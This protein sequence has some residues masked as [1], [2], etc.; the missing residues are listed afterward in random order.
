MSF[1]MRLIQSK[2]LSNIHSPLIHRLSSIRKLE[3]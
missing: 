1:V 2:K 3:L